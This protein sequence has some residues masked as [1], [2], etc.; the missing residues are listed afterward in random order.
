VAIP[1]TGHEHRV[2]PV[3]AAFYA[4]SVGELFVQV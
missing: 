4:D 3:V 1:D 2:G